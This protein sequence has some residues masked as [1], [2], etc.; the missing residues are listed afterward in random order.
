MLDP[1][2]LKIFLIAAEELNFSRAA[3]KLHLS[4]PS[5]TQHIRALEKHFNTALFTRAGKKISLT[6]A[7]YALIPLARQLLTINIKTDDLMKNINEDIHGTLTI[8]CSTTPG[9]YILPL[10]LA[11]FIKTHPRVQVTCNVTSRAAALKTLEDGK[12]DIALSSSSEVF[13][14]DIEFKKIFEEPI[15]LIAHP[16]HPWRLRE[17]I[18]L[19]EMVKA[20]FILREKTSGTY[21]VLRARLAEK[22]F[23]MEDLRT[24][25]TLGNT[26]SIAIAV[27]ENVGVGFI[28]KIVYDNMP[29][30]QVCKINIQ[31]FDVHQNIYVARHKLNPNTRIQSAFW[32]F[33]N[34]PYNPVLG[35][36]TTS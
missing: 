29:L 32:E 16:D 15:I 10:L 35:K 24:V 8:G 13:S 11:E 3:E 7:G 33:V 2:Q 22:G 21:Q 30:G 25:L 4:Q 36:Y 19:S 31:D 6:E 14:N 18:P 23:N 34:D 20:K 28:S 27:R 26:E 12:V 9:K 17:T 1:N 5:V